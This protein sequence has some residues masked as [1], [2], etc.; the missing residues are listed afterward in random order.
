MPGKTFIV[1]ADGNGVWGDIP[2]PQALTLEGIAA[3]VHDY[4]LAARN[5]M[6]AG[7][8]GVEIHA[9]NGYLL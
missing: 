8:D 2:T 4:R 6:E 5:A 1:D 9:G 7:M 3:I